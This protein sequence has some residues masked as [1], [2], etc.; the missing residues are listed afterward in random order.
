M[1][2]TIKSYEKFE[3]RRAPKPGMLAVFDKDGRPVS[4]WNEQVHGSRKL[5]IMKNVDARTLPP[6]VFPT[7]E[8]ERWEDNPDCKIPTNA[9]EISEEHYRAFIKHPGRRRMCPERKELVA[10]EPRSVEGG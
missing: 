10:C 9:V 6:G 1:S 7:F 3:R 2:D 8:I 5:P 4:F